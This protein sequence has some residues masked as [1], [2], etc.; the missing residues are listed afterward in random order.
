MRFG[1]VTFPGSNCDQDCVYVLRS[2]LGQDV[3]AV[4][5]EDRSLDGL[6]AIVLPGGF[7]H[8]DYLRAGAIAARAPVMS[9]V[10]AFARAGRPVL[11]ICNGFQVLLEAGLLPGAM[12]RNQG[13]RFRCLPVFVRVESTN[14]AWTKTLREG[15]VLQL[16]IAHGEGNYFA[17]EPLLATMEDEHQVVF[18]YS[19]ADGRLASSANPNGS[20][21]HIAGVCNPAG[22]VIGLMPHPERASES[23]LGSADG[24]LLFESVLSFLST[25]RMSPAGA[26]R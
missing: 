22:N 19:D 26:L 18:R 2:V 12:L 7:A 11:G 23:V 24:R 6:D 13:L 3:D 1:V 10:G 17:P 15:Q 8:G 16:P 5:H 20:V 21:R 25:R 4:W 9:A 14:T